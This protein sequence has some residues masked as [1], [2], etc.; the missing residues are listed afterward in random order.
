MWLA[1]MLK[2]IHTKINIFFIITLL[3]IVFPIL[4]MI[5]ISNGYG[6]D[7]SSAEILYTGTHSDILYSSDDYAYYKIYCSSNHFLKVILTYSSSFD[8]DLRLYSP[9]Q[10]LIDSSAN[11]GTADTCGAYCSFSGYYYIRVKRFSGT[12]D[13]SFYLDISIFYGIPGFQIVYLIFGLIGCIG[14]FYFLKVRKNN[15]LNKNII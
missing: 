11:A 2:R 14:L 9:S 12:G 7:F 4:Y 5:P 10:S 1:K 15:S 6:D 13:A 8:L 3:F